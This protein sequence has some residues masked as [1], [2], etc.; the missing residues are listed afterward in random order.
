MALVWESKVIIICAFEKVRE[1][2][3][4]QKNLMGLSLFIIISSCYF[5]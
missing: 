4:R 2:K 1:N 3:K 5:I